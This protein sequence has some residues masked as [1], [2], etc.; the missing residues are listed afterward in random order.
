MKRWLQYY[1]LEKFLLIENQRLRTTPVE[2]LHRI[3]TFIGVKHYFTTKTLQWHGKKDVSHYNYMS[4][5][6]KRILIDYFRPHTLHF[7]DIVG[8]KFPWK[9]H[10]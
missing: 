6:T 1:P 4:K 2:V 8:R 3:E 7:F 5:Q 10:P 9:L